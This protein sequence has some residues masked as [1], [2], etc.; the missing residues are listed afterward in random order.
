VIAA[1]DSRGS[2]YFKILKTTGT[3]ETFRAFLIELLWS[4]ASSGVN[5][6]EQV[7]LLLD[8]ASTHLSK[9]C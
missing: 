1:V 5:P 7:T 9:A 3:G 6:R 8:N 2:L 4:Y